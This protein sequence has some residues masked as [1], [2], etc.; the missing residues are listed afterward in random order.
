MSVESDGGNGS[1]ELQ[2]LTKGFSES[3]YH[4]SG[5]MLKTVQ[6]T[7]LL[8]RSRFIKRFYHLD[9]QERILR[10]FSFKGD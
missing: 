2:L 6:S 3:D 5:W 7:G 8:T 1:K 4:I 9:K 10:I